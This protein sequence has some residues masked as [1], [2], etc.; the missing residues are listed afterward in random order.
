MASED[1]SEEFSGAASAPPSEQETGQRG[2]LQGAQLKLELRK[3]L[4]ERRADLAFI[5]QHRRSAASADRDKVR[6]LK[7]S[8]GSG[9][10]AAA[11]EKRTG[12]AC[13]NEDVSAT[14]T[15]R[16]WRN[17]IEPGRRDAC[18]DAPSDAA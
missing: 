7:E 10:V 6:A 17:E 4:S 14:S 13:S 15:W 16:Q 12:R 2:P 3:Y 5:I 8:F 1:Q 11:L 9:P 18:G